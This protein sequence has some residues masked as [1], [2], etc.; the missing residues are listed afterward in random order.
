MIARHSK[1][2]NMDL[3]P[4]I[5]GETNGLICKLCTTLTHIGQLCEGIMTILVKLVLRVVFTRYFRIHE[6]IIM[7]CIPGVASWSNK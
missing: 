4:I 2:L 1:C 6:S 5:T 3:V 7:L